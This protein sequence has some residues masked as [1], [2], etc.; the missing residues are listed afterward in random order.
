MEFM[1]V[2]SRFVEAL[3]LGL[4]PLLVPILAAYVIAKIRESW[5]N[6]TAWNPVVTEYIEKAVQIAVLA[7]EQAQVG[8]FIQDKKKFALSIAE[9]WLAANKITVDLDLLSAAI[10]AAVMSEFNKGRGTLLPEI[11][12]QE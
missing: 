12:D 3:L 8:G 7:A 10:E 1:D 4:V 6:A 11:T 9:K 5:K 2:L